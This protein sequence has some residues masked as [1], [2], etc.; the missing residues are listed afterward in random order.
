MNTKR[1]PLI[2]KE[3]GVPRG[4]RSRQRASSDLRERERE[5]RGLR[6]RGARWGGKG[7]KGE[8]AG[9]DQCGF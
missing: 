4:E 7:T 8:G 6:E 9:R 2:E 5:G 3:R 1:G